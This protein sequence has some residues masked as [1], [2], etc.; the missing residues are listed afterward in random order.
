MKRLKQWFVKL[1]TIWIMLFALV[2]LV[3]AYTR[4]ADASIKLYY[5]TFGIPIFL[6]LLQN[7]L[8]KK[9]E[10]N[11]CNI[12]L[13]MKEKIE[14][15]MIWKLRNDDFQENTVYL[16]I[17]NTGKIDIF[18]IYIKVS[19]NDGGIGWFQIPEMLNTEK[20]YI[21]RVPY[22]KETIKEIVLSCSVQTECRT[23]KFN[24]IKSGNENMTI[25]SNSELLEAEKY[26]I[27]HEMG[28]DVFE[29]ME[30][31]II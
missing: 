30:R 24:G 20:E 7:A 19:K 17:R 18:S 12:D 26:A 16:C 11:Y 8:A 6:F 28:F 3:Y 29:R 14:D 15:K 10:N 13:C 31:F 23:K 21:V 5:T 1:D 4:E 27:Y 2:I 22:K 9:Q 25:F